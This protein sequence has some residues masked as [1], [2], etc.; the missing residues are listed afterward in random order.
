MQRVTLA[1]IAE[2]VGLS[3][4]AVSQALRGNPRIPEATA[5]RVRAAAEALDY[6]PDPALRALSM[7]KRQRRGETFRGE[8]IALISRGP[9]PAP[10]KRRLFVRNFKE[11]I[12]ERAAQLGYAVDTFWLGDYPGESMKR[13][14]LSREIRNIILLPESLTGEYLPL[15][16][17]WNRFSL[18]K[19]GHSIKGLEVTGVAHDL[20]A[21]ALTV[22]DTL[23]A[24]GYRR[25][26]LVQRRRTEARQ[27]FR[28]ASAFLFRQQELPE[29]DRLPIALVDGFHIAADW[30]RA[31]CD[32]HRP[33]VVLST[34]AGVLHSL[35]KLNF[36]VPRDIAFICLDIQK[37][38]PNLSGIDQNQTRIGAG[39]VDQIDLLHRTNQRGLLAEARMTVIS[40][41]WQEGATLPVKAGGG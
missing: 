29:A 13:L 30:M 15:D 19:I 27:D 39:A 6:A 32:R 31:Y 34:T 3:K 18:V 37:N 25:P 41:R 4:S 26:A 1:D 11:G 10:W 35:R 33:D 2:R 14:L 20:F 36:R 21:S 8:V 5:R 12:E 38:Q 22:F 24:R 28:W 16:L 23:R 40:G 9:K 17:P 7:H